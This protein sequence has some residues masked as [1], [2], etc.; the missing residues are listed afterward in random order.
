MDVCKCIVLS[1]HGGTLNNLQAASP[2]MRLVEGKERRETPDHLQ[3]VLSQNWGGT[4][5]NHN[6]T[7][8]V[9]KAKDSKRIKLRTKRR[10]QHVLVIVDLIMAHIT[11]GLLDLITRRDRCYR[12]PDCGR[13]CNQA[14]VLKHHLKTHTGQMPPLRIQIH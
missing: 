3:G 7:G 9:L 10:T 11:K 12:C 14:I 8:M 2:R 1:R 13:V 5:Q 6:V 4:K